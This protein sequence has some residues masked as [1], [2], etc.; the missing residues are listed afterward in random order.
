MDR[1]LLSPAL[2]ESYTLGQG[3]PTVSAFPCSA[4]NAVAKTVEEREVSQPPCHNCTC[5]SRATSQRPFHLGQSLALGYLGFLSPWTLCLT[6]Q[7]DLA[8][9]EVARDMHGAVLCGCPSAAL[10]VSVFPCF[11]LGSASVGELDPSTASWKPA[12]GTW[13]SRLTEVWVFLD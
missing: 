7:L 5:C 2:C 10:A 8:E 6:S 12:T 1:A 11:L 9:L 3:H 13:R 4:A